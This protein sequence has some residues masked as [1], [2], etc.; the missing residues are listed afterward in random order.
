MENDDKHR[1]EL[2][3]R[4]PEEISF[5]VWEGLFWMPGAVKGLRLWY[6]WGGIDCLACALNAPLFATL[7]TH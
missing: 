7:P 4:Q 6:V 3:G 2:Q 1:T 5:S